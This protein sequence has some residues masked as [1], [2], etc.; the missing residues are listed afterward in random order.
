MEKRLQDTNPDKNNLEKGERFCPDG[1]SLSPDEEECAP[2]I[3][4]AIEGWAT[5]TDVHAG[6]QRIDGRN[7]MGFND[8]VSNP[9]SNPQLF[10]K[11]VWTTKDSERDILK[12]G[13]YMVFQKIEHDLDRMT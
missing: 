12:D 3:V 10:N 11:V 8:D 4:S 6:F 7:L 13:I 2:D 1:P 5:I 9:T